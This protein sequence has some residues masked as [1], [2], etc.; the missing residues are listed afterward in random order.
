MVE[1]EA[2][3]QVMRHKGFNDKWL[4]WSSDFLS[5]GHSMV[6]LNGV[7]GRQ[8]EC[9]RGVRQGDP[10]SPLYYLFGLDLLQSSV[11]DLVRLGQLQKLID[12]YDDDFPI[13][14]YADDTLLIM[15]AD[16]DQ[17]IVLKELLH[18]F[19]LSTCLKINY[20]KS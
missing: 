4:K 11:N 2:I 6:L 15:P 13:I 7:P 10:I 14:Q 12:T 3:L 9:K 20:N 19:A 8:F 18:K 1:H 5:T 17:I 16:R